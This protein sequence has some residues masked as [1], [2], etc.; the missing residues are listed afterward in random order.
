ME[1]RIN[2]ANDGSQYQKYQK[3][4]VLKEGVGVAAGL[5]A[6]TAAQY[7]SLPVGMFAM[8]K[9]QKIGKSCSEADVVEIRRGMEKALDI[10]GMKS[11]GVSIIDYAGT[12][13]KNEKLSIFGQ[14][15]RAIL[16]QVNMGAAITEGRNAG[17]SNIANKVVINTEKLGP[18]GFHEIGHSINFNNSKFWRALQKYRTFAPLVALSLA[19]VAILKR[20]KA[21]GEQPTGIIDKTTTFIKNNVGKLAFGAMIPVVAEETMASV[22]GNKLAKSLLSPELAKKVLKSNRLGALSYIGAAVA[23]GLAATFGSKVRDKIAS[24]KPVQV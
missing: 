4:G 10:T 5:G 23:M 7:L 20:K 15:K 2:Y 13:I 16:D 3:S 6:T 12:P 9:M 24:P 11:K 17:Y 8:D 22:R 21:D 18:V 19:G 1:T 14:V